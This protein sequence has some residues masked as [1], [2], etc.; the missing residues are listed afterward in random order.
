LNGSAASAFCST[1]SD[2]LVPNQEIETRTA[3][4]PARKRSAGEGA[5]TVLIYMMAPQ[6]R[7]GIELATGQRTVEVL[8]WKRKAI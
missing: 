4:M 5:R 7:G 8:R 6:K 1:V 2:F 3:A